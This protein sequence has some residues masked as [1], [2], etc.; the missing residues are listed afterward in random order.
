MQRPFRT[1]VNR[2]PIA[3]GRV[4]RCPCSDGE[5][6]GL[7]DARHRLFQIEIIGQGLPH[8]ALEHGIL[9]HVQPSEVSK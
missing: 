9:K 2:A 7:L 3:R 1:T 8:Q 6:S 4:Q 5:V